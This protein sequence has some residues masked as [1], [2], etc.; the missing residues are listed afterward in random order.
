[1]SSVR[2]VPGQ[3][4]PIDL[5]GCDAHEPGIIGPRFT[6]QA[7]PEFLADDVERST[8][9]VRDFHAAAAAVDRR[10]GSP[11]LMHP[12]QGTLGLEEVARA[13][14]LGV[15][16]RHGCISHLDRRPDPAD[17]RE[18]LASG[19]QVND[20]RAFRGRPE[21]GN[22]TRDL[23]VA[24]LP[25]FPGQ[26]LLAM[27]AARRGY[28]RRHGG[29]PGLSFLTNEFSAQLWAAEMTDAQ[30]QD[31]FVPPPAGTG[32]FHQILPHEKNLENRWHQ[33]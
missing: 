14:E 19:L 4:A 33:F 13:R 7:A 11:I 5:G 23:V 22:P 21:Q 25:E 2:T 6:T 24:R 20:E 17:H 29:P 16:V 32:A 31:V 15:A 10:T 9:E 3:I 27:D 18:M 1:M 30:W 26:I 8:T 12:E 28:W